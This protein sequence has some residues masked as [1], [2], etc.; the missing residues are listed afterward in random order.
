MK[1]RYPAYFLVAL[2]VLI[3][4][5]MTKYLV[6]GRL[7]LFEVINVLPFFN[8]VY[9]EN[10]GS[11]FGMFRGLGNT[12]FIFFAAAAILVVV[13]MIIK[14]REN[15]LGFSLIL[16]GASGNL[17]DRLLHGHVIDF[18]DVYAGRYHWPSFNVADSALTIGIV[19]L[20]FKVNYPRRKGAAG[21]K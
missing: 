14:D 2:I 3:L 8:I 11:A 20:F 10:V 15:R 6:R 19:L 13:V 5:Q 17:I 21:L 1:N 4:D 7:S 9:V 12:F 16:G 18:L